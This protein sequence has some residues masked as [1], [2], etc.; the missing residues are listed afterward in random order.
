MAVVATRRPND[1]QHA[2]SEKACRD[3][4]DLAIVVPMVDAIGRFASKNLLG[5]CEIQ[6][7][8]GQRPFALFWVERYVHLM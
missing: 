8:L 1:D 5:F 2:A 7:S 6:P 4:S 3:H